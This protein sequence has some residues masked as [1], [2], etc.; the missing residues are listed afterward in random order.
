[1]GLAYVPQSR[2]KGATSGNLKF[3]NPKLAGTYSRAGTIIQ[4][5]HFGYRFVKANYKLFTGIGAVAT[6]AGVSLLTPSGVPIGNET[7]NQFRKTY[8]TKKFTS[9]PRAGKR[10]FQ[11]RTR[12]R[13]TPRRT[14][15]GCC[16]CC[17]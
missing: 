8:R 7:D 6:G 5:L 10:K 2:G 17:H 15:T 11:S 14:H 3:Y 9:Y 16:R 13:R 12:Y 1:M 4:G